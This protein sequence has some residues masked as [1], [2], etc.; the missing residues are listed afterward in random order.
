MFRYLHA[1]FLAFLLI[2]NITPASAYALQGLS[3]SEQKADNQTDTAGNIVW[4]EN[5]RPFGEKVN[6][7]AAAADNRQ[8][9]HGKAVDADTGLQYFGARYYDPVLGRFMG[10]DPV[11]FQEDNIHSFNKYAYGNNNPYR[12]IDPDGRQSM[13]II[14][15]VW[16]RAF[17]NSAGPNANGAAGFEIAKQGVVQ[18]YFDG[19]KMSAE[20]GLLISPLGLVRTELSSGRKLDFLFNNNIS[21]ANAARAKGNADRIGIADTQANRVEVMRRMNEAYQY[22]GSIVEGGSTAGRNM[23]E[24]FLP[25]VTSTGS[26]IQFVEEA[27]K[28]ITIIAK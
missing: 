26:K 14:Y 17:S 25:G 24:F 2:L 8:W 12:F 11:G 21:P 3:M 15:N 18:G 23:R 7:Q 20:V 28:V 1:I 27:G 4:R 9:F 19:L 6:N 5:Y 13:D 22:S 10:V 16:N